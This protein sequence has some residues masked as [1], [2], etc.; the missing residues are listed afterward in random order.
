MELTFE[1]AQTLIM[2]EAQGEEGLPVC[3]RSGDDPGA[4]RMARLVG[5]LWEV[6]LGLQDQASIDR[7]LAAALH[8]LSSYVFHQVASGTR[9]RSWRD[10]F[11]AREVVQL[12]EAIES[13]F[14]GEPVY[15]VNE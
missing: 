8:A 10:E 14:E 5:A 12:G 6:Y 15:W 9:S 7:R 1:A 13:I 11:V 4:E 2:R 3:V